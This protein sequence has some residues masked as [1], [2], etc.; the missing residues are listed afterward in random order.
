MPAPLSPRLS[1]AG[2]WIT[3][4][5]STAAAILSMFS[6][7]RTYGMIGQAGPAHLAI[8]A[9]GASWVGLTPASAT[10]TSIGDTIHLAATVT[11]KS[12]SVLVGSWLQWTSEDTTVATVSPSGMVIARAPGQTTVILLV[13]TLIARSRITVKPEPFAVRF[14]PDSGVTVTEGGHARPRPHV[15]DAR[16]YVMAGEVPVLRTMDSTIATADSSGLILAHEAGETT[17]EATVRGI[18]ARTPIRVKAVPSSITPVS[19]LEQNAT[20]GRPL[21]SPVVVRVLSLRGRP[22]AGTPVYFAAADGQ[23]RPDPETVMT[24]STGRART[25]WTLGDIPGPQRLLVR[26]E[27]LDSATVVVAEANPIAANVRHS[28]IGDAQVAPAGDSLPLPVGVRVTDSTGRALMDIPVSWAAPDADSLIALSTRTDSLG[29]AHARWILGPKAGVHRARV[30][31]G[32]TRALPAYPLT[33]L[34][35]PGAPKSVTVQRGQAQRGTA[36]SV[37]AQAVV[38]R[39]ADGF[40]NP[41][42]GATVTFTPSHGSTG[43]TVLAT[44]SLGRASVR[45]TVGGA[46]GS[47]KLVAQVS[48][49]AKPLEIT[50]EVAPGRASAAAFV[51]PPTAGTVAKAL[52]SPVTV[53]IT[54][55]HG[56]P[57][58]GAPVSFAAAT[59]SV[60]PRKATT[61]A[62]G[63]ATTKWTLGARAGAQKLT[64]S[65]SGTAAKAILEVE[66]T[67]AAKPA[68]KPAAKAATTTPVAKKM[69]ARPPAAKTTAKPPATTPRKKPPVQGT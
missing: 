9:L 11:N 53:T 21:P 40:D 32:A 16:G 10:A 41:V 61:D 45:W 24:D 34:A 28:L 6:I 38:L 18:T 44:D 63:R 69:S 68:A 14:V 4:S 36:G 22:I 25:T 20:V 39:V 64:A 42:A 58:A 15:V 5:V 56:N 3:A 8:G 55:A 57:I 59:G 52:A 17:L 50:A 48:G 7:A 26:T 60:A 65:V 35:R 31:I 13:G 1:S 46:V 33:A 12:G 43:D 67:A 23:G 37:L 47:Q 54:D 51:A 29:E 30:Q 66:A 49:V 19:R 62:K 27:R 2:K